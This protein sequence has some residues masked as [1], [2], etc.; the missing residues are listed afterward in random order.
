MNYRRIAKKCENGN[1]TRDCELR[2]PNTYYRMCPPCGKKP[3]NAK[4][5]INYDQT[6]IT[7]KI[8]IQPIL[9]PNRGLPDPNCSN[10][11]SPN[12]SKGCFYC[13]INGLN[14]S[15]HRSIICRAPGNRYSGYYRGPGA[16]P[17]HY[18]IVCSRKTNHIWHQNNGY[19]QPW[20]RCM[21]HS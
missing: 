1:C 16:I 14:S 3:A 8:P 11:P 15:T 18:C 19:E 20:L 12:H 2:T 4:A 7:V 13:R 17:N 10:N 5:I 21:V 6:Y 9:K